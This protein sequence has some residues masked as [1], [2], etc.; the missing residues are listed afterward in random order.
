MS[1]LEAVFKK[2]DSRYFDSCLQKFNVKVKC[3]TSN[4]LYYNINQFFFYVSSITS[5]KQMM[6][7]T[8]IIIMNAP[9][10]L[11]KS[12]YIKFFKEK[13][14][15]M[16][17]VVEKLH[18][19]TLYCNWKESCYLD[20]LLACLMYSKL[21]L[22]DRIKSKKCMLTSKIV[23]DYTNAHKTSSKEI[24]DEVIKLIPHDYASFSVSEVYDAFSDFYN[25][26]FSVPR[27][28]VGGLIE[29]MEFRD[30]LVSHQSTGMMSMWDFLDRST[31][32]T[33]QG[34]IH[35]WDGVSSDYLVFQNTM[36]PIITMYDEGH[37]MNFG[38]YILEKKYRLSGVII[39]K[40]SRP[41]VDEESDGHYVCYVRSRFNIDAWFYYDD[42]KD[43][44]WRFVGDLPKIVFK[45]TNRS[46]PELFFYE[47][48]RPI[49]QKISIPPIIKEKWVGANGK[50]YVFYKKDPTLFVITKKDLVK[51]NPDYRYRKGDTNTF[52]WK[53]KDKKI[54]E[55]V[56]NEITLFKK[57]KS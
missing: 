10:S 6:I 57:G 42:L 48:V 22:M 2:L 21:P 15:E 56:K 47:K 41:S 11:F 25:L 12:F 1:D 3:S 28:V 35:L 18:Y 38:E 52:V 17:I 14:L 50:A 32:K 53:V 7:H 30:N 9:P 24:R 37:Y 39:Q 54:V 36:A 8:T 49:R 55:D 44:K 27:I 29:N 46:R 19:P 16:M 45:D 23:N 34:T 20:C 31:F 51:L 13:P 4:R 43:G 26:K 33:G 40:G 5:I